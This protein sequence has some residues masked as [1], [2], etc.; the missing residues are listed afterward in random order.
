MKLAAVRAIANLAKEPV[1]E[2]VNLA[3]NQRTISF[4]RDYI[5]PKPF[6]PRLITTVA[7]AVAKAAMD[8]GVALYPIKDWEAYDEELF[9]RLG[10][11]DKFIRLALEKA[12]AN[13]KRVVFSDGDSYKVLKAS[14]IL[15]DEGIATPILLGN[16][17]KIHQ[18]IEEY[19]LA[20]EDVEIISPRDEEEKLNEFAQ[21]YWQ[22]RKRKG[23]TL[24]EAKKL[25][26]HREYFGSMMVDFGEADVL[27][28]GL[29]VKYST[30]VR[31]I[32]EI[33]GTEQNSRTVSGLYVLLT[34]RGPLY[35]AD[36]TI[37]EDPTVE[38][39]VDIT[40][41]TARSMKRT[42]L[43]PKVALLSYS[44]FGSHKG[45]V[46]SKMHKAIEILHERHPDLIVDGEMQA[47]F[48]LDKELLSEVFPFS[49]LVGKRP[50][51]F[52]FPD[53][54]SGNISYKLLQSFGAVEAI[55]PMLIGLNKS[56][57]VLQMGSSVREIVNMT[58]L[59]VIDAQS[60]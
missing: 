39:I 3:Y 56:A 58:T 22:K 11:D 25:L 42:N 38:E 32:L 9:S 7:P 10:R 2:L 36:T 15:I 17:E 21:A 35:L 26:K 54:A 46:P 53:L 14:Q 30:G 40:V 33:I 27:I 44:N 47:N 52:I 12:K 6:D 24:Y 37:N 41:N 59:A 34:K 50:N 19:Q 23:V 16:K 29:T 1:P 18:M 45:D 51:V 28:S 55:G 48:A 13:P 8:S 5:I 57:H 31:P 20:I 43:I 60:R 49:D 4:G